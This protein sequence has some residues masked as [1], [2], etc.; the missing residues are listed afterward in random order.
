M[1]SFL[2]WLFG[3]AQDRT[4]RRY[5]KIV[6]EVNRLEE[7]MQS[8]SDEAL[9]AKTQEFRTRLA[10]GESLDQLLPEGYA[11]VKDCCRRMLGIDVHVS[12]YN[13][14]WDMIPIRCPDHWSHRPP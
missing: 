2:K 6:T 9:A 3:T 10:A 13:Q 14:K 11:V 5:Q 4:L 12:G 8:L 1:L 7:G